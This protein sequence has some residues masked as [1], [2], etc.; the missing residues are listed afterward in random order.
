MRTW[1]VNLTLVDGT[2]AAPSPSSAVLVGDDGTLLEVA[3]GGAAEVPDGE[4]GVAVVDCTGLTMTPGL[5][6]AHSHLGFATDLDAMLQREISTAELALDIFNV[7]EDALRAGFT[8]IRDVGG[9]EGAVPEL[10]E[11]GKMPGPRV[12]T[13]GPIQCQTG[14]HGHLGGRWESTDLFE[15]HEIPGLRTMAFLGDGPETVRRNVRETFRRGA[16]FVKMCVTGGVLTRGTKPGDTQFTVD[17][18]R[19]AVEEAEA[20]GTYVTVHAHNTAGVRRAVEAGVKCVEH[21]SNLDRETAELMAKH[22]VA[23]VP[24]LAPG[25]IFADKIERLRRQGGSVAEGFAAQFDV[26][27]QMVASMRTAVPL[28]RDAG[29]LVGLGADITGPRQTERAMELVLRAEIEDPMTVLVSATRDNATLCRLQDRVGTVVAGL[30]A[31]LCLWSSSPLDDPDVFTQRD[32]LALVLQGGRPVGGTRWAGG[33][34][35]RSEDGTSRTVVA[36][37]DGRGAE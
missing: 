4:A 6:D 28:A 34:T 1:Y 20:R 26:A 23:L 13:A 16:D 24:T 5:I 35:V 12:L 3:P 21:G 27:E 32:Q 17:E 8:T 7:C 29:L 11:R 2:G 10:I 31:D 18:I 25:V 19:A 36:N 33:D 30:E 37:Q 14:G 15:T 22:D 9:L